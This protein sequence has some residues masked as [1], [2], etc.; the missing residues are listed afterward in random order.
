MSWIG[1]GDEQQR[2]SWL[3]VRGRTPM[4]AA[5]AVGDAL[6]APARYEIGLAVHQTPGTF[7]WAT[8]SVNLS[9]S[10]VLGALLTLVRER[11]PPTRFVRP[12]A[13]IG[14]LGAYTT[15]STFMV[16]ADLLVKGGQV[17]VA[18]GYAGATLVLGLGAAYVG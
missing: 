15:W 1:I 8:F 17:G 2:R 9:G 16:D 5:I 10:F 7:P 18:L 4:C 3:G 6:G 14:F 12:F 11:W 13:A